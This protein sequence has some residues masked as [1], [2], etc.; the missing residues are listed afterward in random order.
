MGTALLDFRIN[1][2]MIFEKITFH[3]VSTYF[4]F[5]RSV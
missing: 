4:E 3:F 2:R 1:M 5:I